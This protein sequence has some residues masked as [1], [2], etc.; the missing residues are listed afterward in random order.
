VRTPPGS[1]EHGQRRAVDRVLGQERLGFGRA[2]VEPRM[3]LGGADEEVA[4]RVVLGIH[5]LADHRHVLPD[6]AH[7][8]Q[9]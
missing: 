6:G 1:T 4:E 7:A 2:R 3:R 8:R 9:R 5:P